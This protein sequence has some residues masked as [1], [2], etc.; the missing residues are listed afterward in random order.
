MFSPLYRSVNRYMDPTK[1]ATFCAF[2]KPEPVYLTS[3]VV[4]FFLCS[5]S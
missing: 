3:R 1:P 5:V 4:V 2:P